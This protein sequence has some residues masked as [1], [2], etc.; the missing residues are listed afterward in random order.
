MDNPA[1]LW[2]RTA[3]AWVKLAELPAKIQ[4]LLP[5]IALEHAL[6]RVR[7]GIEQHQIATHLE[8]WDEDF[9][10]VWSM[11]PEPRMPEPRTTAEWAEVD[12]SGGTFR[13][14]ALLVSWEDVLTVLADRA[15]AFRPTGATKQSRPPDAAVRALLE[16]MR[17]NAERQGRK[18]KRDPTIDACREQLN[19]TVEQAKK[20]LVEVV[21]KRLRLKQGERPGQAVHSGRAGT[22]RRPANGK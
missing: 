16:A 3:P 13:G 2:G 21:P 17:D 5:K 8:G 14:V 18:L 11:M 20:L 6:G 4:H 15:P 7:I 22:N 10:F 9:G 12:W 19:A 1:D